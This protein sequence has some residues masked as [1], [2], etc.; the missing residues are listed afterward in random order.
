MLTRRT[1][2]LTRTSTRTRLP[3]GAA[4]A[5]AVALALAACGNNATGNAI[6]NGGGTTAAS[7]SA[8]GDQITAIPSLKGD[9]TTIILD[10]GTVSA[11][12]SLGLTLAPAGNAAFDA[13]KGEITFPITSGYAEIHSDKSAKP[14]Y[15]QGSIQHEGSG[16]TL[17][18]GGTVVTLGEFVVDPGSSRLFGSVRVGDSP[19]MVDVPLLD[20]DG[21]GLEITKPGGKVQL[22]G[23][24]AKLTDTAAQALNT[25]F[26]TDKLAA[27]LPLGVVR[28]VADAT[29][30]SPYPASDIAASI[31]RLDG[32]GTSVLLDAGTMGA[33][34]G[35]GV[36]VA[37]SGSG[38]S[39]MVMGKP[40]VT[41]PIT[42]GFVVIHKDKTYK[43]GYI[44][45]IVVHEGSGL[46]FS[47][48]GKALSVGDFEVD[49]GS[50]TLT[51][52]VNGKPGFPLLALDGSKVE[53]QVDGGLP[54]LF[55]TVAA[56]TE[57]AAQALNTTFGTDALTAGTP[58]GVVRLVA[59]PAKG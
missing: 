38:K 35:L 11:L 46:T 40:A 51:A 55:G 16:F 8:S 24:V 2:P 9:G 28:L 57:Q 41:F 29:G 50:S 42:N 22:F 15:V 33:L 58:L 1:R 44:A 14:G 17:T 47:A 56:L 30:A 59:S 49:P 5:A 7:A 3:A 52:S 19:A 37:P 21:S 54:V 23:T 6:N 10:K 53:V 39:E 25:V 36:S 12:T 34:K 4:V 45:G 20:L 18:G 31:P 43:P 27:G 13:A 26:K 48:G 32:Q